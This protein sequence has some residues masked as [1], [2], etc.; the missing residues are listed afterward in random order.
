MADLS[1][2]GCSDVNLNHILWK[3]RFIYLNFFTRLWRFIVGTRDGC[4][5]LQHSNAFGQLWNSLTTSESVNN[6]QF[7]YIY[8]VFH[9]LVTAF[10]FSSITMQFSSGFLAHQLC[11]WAVVPQCQLTQQSLLCSS[12]LGR[13][14]QTVEQST[15]G[16]GLASRQGPQKDLLL[17]TFIHLIISCFHYNAV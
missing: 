14:S 9:F 7:F 5:I 17:P 8:W 4:C 11:E 13:N 2:T 3:D 6:F 16:S 1:A 12:S 15:C 10:S